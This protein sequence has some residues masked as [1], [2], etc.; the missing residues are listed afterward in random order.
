MTKTLSVPDEVHKELEKE[1]AS[2]YESFGSVI[3]RLI[4]EHR[5]T[6]RNK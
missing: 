4:T 1:K 5:E 2:D 6:L 3:M